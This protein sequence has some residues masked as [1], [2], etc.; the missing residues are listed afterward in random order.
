MHVV[1]VVARHTSDV[2]PSMPEWV[3][4]HGLPQIEK[5]CWGG[6]ILL[7]TFVR[8]SRGY[9]SYLVLHPEAFLTVGGA[10][11]GSLL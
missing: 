3:P 4:T 5:F 9:Y 8:M 7:Y 1:V 2:E 11:S 6:G 10:F